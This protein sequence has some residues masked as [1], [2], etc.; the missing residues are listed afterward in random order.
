MPLHVLDPDNKP[1]ILRQIYGPDNVQL[2]ESKTNANDAVPETP[3]TL[4]QF[5]RE[6]DVRQLQEQLEAERKSGWG[7]KAQQ[8]QDKIN[9]AKD[10]AK[11]QA[12]AD[13]NSAKAAQ[14]ARHVQF[15]KEQDVRGNIQTKAEKDAEDA[16]NAQPFAVRHPYLAEGAAGAGLAAAFLLPQTQKIRNVTTANKTYQRAGN[17]SQEVRDRLG[18]TGPS[19]KKIPLTEDDRIAYSRAL[20]KELSDIDAAEKKTHPSLLG[21]T[22]SSAGGALGGAGMTSM[23]GSAPIE[24]DLQYLQP[25]NSEAQKIMQ[26][27]NSLDQ[28]TRM[29]IFAGAGAGAGLAGAKVPSLKS[30]TVPPSPDLLQML[31]RVR[32]R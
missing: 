26:N 30:P 2:A 24:T 22:I 5:Y 17:T 23:F 13:F 19:G 12:L 28:A 9:A 11:A 29:G 8:L 27:I 31:S 4:E 14:N 6:P 7:N 16:R 18:I 1:E 32:K 10:A 25:S 15:Q 20:R 3:V 21:Q